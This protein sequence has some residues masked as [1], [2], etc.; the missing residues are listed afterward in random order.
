[1]REERMAVLRMLEKGIITAE[2]AE[3]LILALQNKE[4]K[5]R[6]NTEEISDGISDAL[7]KVGDVLGSF[8]K[9]VSE[10]AEGVA[11]EM[12]P[13]VKKMAETVADK[14]SSAAEELK[15]YA[16]SKK[17]EKESDF[18]QEEESLKEEEKIREK[19]EELFANNT[20]DCSDDEYE[21]QELEIKKKVKG[22]GKMTPEE[23][24]NLAFQE[25]LTSALA[26]SNEEEEL[27][28]EEESTL[29]EKEKTCC[30]RKTEECTR[31]SPCCWS[32]EAVDWAE[33][34]RLMDEKREKEKN[35]S[36]EEKEE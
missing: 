10:K 28:D 27:I 12:E 23:F 16:S 29:C 18:S 3:R 7:N 24:K 15:N 31:P 14:A 20:E 26:I 32:T 22:M 25:E 2:E 6:I 19:Y 21:K 30:G 36:K 13:V 34:W 4:V 1:M 9:T 5:E 33:E 35:S 8:V 17:K 11:K